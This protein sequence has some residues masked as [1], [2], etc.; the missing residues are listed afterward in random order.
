MKKKKKV[1][2]TPPLQPVMRQDGC[3]GCLVRQ[4]TIEFLRDQLR[5]QQQLN[6]QLQ[7]KLLALTGD[8]ADRYQKLRVMELASNNSPS[9]TGLVPMGS[10][11][12]EQPHDEFDEF[13][14]FVDNLHGG[15]IK[16]GG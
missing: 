8:A 6:D 4:E 15:L 1:T 11:R 12:E 7:N 3:P 14:E 16:R 9:M 13:D 5:T 10:L 2:S